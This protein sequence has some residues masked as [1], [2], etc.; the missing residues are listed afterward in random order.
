MQPFGQERGAIL[1]AFSGADVQ[2][3]TRKVDVLDPQRHAFVDAQARAIHQLR[4][5]PDHTR[6]LLQDGFHFLAREDHRYQVT[7]LNPL[8]PGH[9]AQGLVQHGIVEKDQGVEGLGLRGRGKVSL[10]RQMVQ[11]GFH[12]RPGHGVRVALSV[13]KDELP[14]PETIAVFSAGAE[15]PAAADDGHLVEQAGGGGDTP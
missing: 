12:L 13:E 1:A 7:P 8:E 2:H 15:V 4:H 14:D 11:E 10:T 9:L 6:H 3:S 5:Q